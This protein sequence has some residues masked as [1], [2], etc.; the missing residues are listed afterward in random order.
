M[1]V[2]LLNRM[3]IEDDRPN[4]VLAAQEDNLRVVA[5]GKG[6]EIGVA[7]VQGFKV[8]EKESSLETFIRNR[9]SNGYIVVA[10]FNLHVPLDSV[11]SG[12][13]GL[14]LKG[15]S[16]LLKLVNLFGSKLNAAAL[17]VIL[18]AFAK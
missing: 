11:I 17:S 1:K 10:D 15:D 18:K 8:E 12:L 14:E 13:S 9:E 5:W 4:V 6:R 7:Q 16:L 2:V 3:N